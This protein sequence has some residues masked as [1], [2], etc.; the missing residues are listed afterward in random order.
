M[1]EVSQIQARIA[2]LEALRDHA[3]MI[4]NWFCADVR[5]EDIRTLTVE[6][7]DQGVAR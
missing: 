2:V 6:L 5:N 4:D 1:N 3:S 7:Y